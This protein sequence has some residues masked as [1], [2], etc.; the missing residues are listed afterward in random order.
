MRRREL[1][2]LLGSALIVGRPLRAQQKAMPV[3]GFLGSPTPGSYTALVDAFL[4]GLEE[5][6]YLEGQN[7][8]IE[9]R[10]AEGRF[11]QLPALAA[12]LVGRKV[13]VIAADAVPSTRAAKDATTTIP[14]VFISG[15]DPVERGF[16]ASFARPD[17]NLTGVAMMVAK[18]A[19]KRFELL[20]EMVPQARVIALLVNPNNLQTD[21]VIKGVQEAARAKAVQLPV[22]KASTEGEIDAAFGTL[23]QLQADAL[24]V[25]PDVFLHSRASSSWR[26][27][28]AILSQRSMSGANPSRLAD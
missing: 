10:W 25:G 20:W 16:V 28:H 12:D 24:V 27:R 3:I 14:V 17:G 13:D 18:I 9:Y 19:P 26:W 5:M 2:L 11:E 15:S 8:A 4:H 7:V 22:L 1:M 21:G 23:M 6:G